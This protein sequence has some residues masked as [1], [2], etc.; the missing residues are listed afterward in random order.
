MK[1]QFISPKRPDPKTLNFAKNGAVYFKKED[2]EKFGFIDEELLSIGTDS[3]DPKNE[4]FYIIRPGTGANIDGYKLK[5]RA[6]SWYLQIMYALNQLNIKY[7]ARYEY[8][9]FEDE[10]HKGFKIRVK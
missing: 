10:I 8:E 9:I 1:I 5:R 7:P 2:A 4:Y 6:G 3:D